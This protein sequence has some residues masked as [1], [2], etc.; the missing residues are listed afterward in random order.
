MTVQ[1]RAEIFNT[2]MLWNA[3]PAIVGLLGLI[4]GLTCLRRLRRRF[5]GRISSRHNL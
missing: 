1:F 2:E 3:A 4:V 5:L